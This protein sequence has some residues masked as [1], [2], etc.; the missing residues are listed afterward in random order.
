MCGGCLRYEH[1]NGYSNES[2]LLPEMLRFKG[3]LVLGALLLAL[4]GLAAPKPQAGGAKAIDFSRDIRPILSDNC[5]ACHG[6]DDKERKAKLRLDQHEDALKPAKSGDYA[7]VPGDTKKSTLVERITTEDEDDVMPPPKTKKKLSPQQKELLTR[8]IAEGAKWQ[9]H[10]AFEAPKRPAPPEVKNE[11]WVR[12]E[13]DQFVLQRLEKEKLKP[14]PEADKPTLVRRATLDLTGLPPTPE[15]VDAFLADKSPGAYEKVVDRLLNSPRYGENM[16]RYWLDAARY[17]DSHGYHIDSE[18]S[19]WKW[20]DWVINAFNDNM[21][22]DQ[23]TVEQLAG[24]L[25]PEASVDQK[26]ASG[27]VRCNMSTGEGG[28]ITGEYQAKYTFDRMETT[29]T[30]WMGLTMTCARCHT[31][32]Y[33]PITHK[34]YYSLYSFFN[35]LNEAVMDGNRPNPDPFIKLPTPEQTARQAELKTWTAEGQKKIEAPMPELDKAQETWQAKWRE[36]LTEGWTVLAST[37]ITSTNGTQFKLLD[38]KSVLVEGPNPDKDVHEV[39][40]PVTE[41]SLAGLR[42]EAVPDESLPNKSAAR[43]ED[44]G[45]RLSEFEVELLRPEKEP[46]KIKFAQ[47]LADST[48]DTYDAAKAIDGKPETGWQAD[49]AA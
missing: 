25:L 31:H 35:N 45:F 9:S 14:A 20:R 19:M 1:L 18:R 4:N 49:P 24:D 36:K 38:D 13:V 6:P 3:T 42:L 46:K 39:I 27:Y 12:N 30:I 26:V 28:A 16:A 33:D 43:S 32:K 44:G 41:G 2:T 34:E 48:R 17:A 10:W 15:E 7:I 29:S 47:A 8:W 22:Y 23:F 37:N 11:K 40:V 5:F 21:P